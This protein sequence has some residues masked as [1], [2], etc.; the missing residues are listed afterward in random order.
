[1]RPDS[2]KKFDML[3]LGSVILGLINFAL[4]YDIIYAQME[5][6]L[7]GSGVEPNSAFLIAGILIGTA[8]SIALWFLISRMRIEFIKW[9]LIVFLI[10]N[11]F[12]LPGMFADGVQLIDMIGVA[13]FA[14]QAAA[15]AFLFR[16]DAKAWFAEK[17]GGGEHRE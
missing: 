16:P 15:I 5:A 6:E 4:G 2:I 3:Y 14:L 7:A 12:S 1:M 8:I 11:L 9:L 17:R 10:W 13:I